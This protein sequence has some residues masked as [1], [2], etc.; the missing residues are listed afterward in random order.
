MK[1]EGR[2]K[3]ENK[4]VGGIR[5]PEPQGRKEPDMHRNNFIC[6]GTAAVT[7]KTV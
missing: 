7:T 5:K 4:V 3:M 2:A 6:R 1:L